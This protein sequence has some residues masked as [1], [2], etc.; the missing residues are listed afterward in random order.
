MTLSVS[1]KIRQI[2][3]A[4]LDAV[5]AELARRKLSYFVRE[6]W[7][8]LEPSTDLVWGL[9]ID[10]ICDH[11]EAVYN[12]RI[13]NLLINIPPG[14]MKSLL[15]SVF[16]Q[17]WIWL[18]NPAWQALYGSYDMGLSTRDTLRFRDLVT[19]DW[20][21]ETFRPRWRPKADQNTK[22]WFANTAGGYH[23][24]V[25][26]SGKGLGFR[27]DA[28]VFDDPLNVKRM[29]TE[30][31]LE[32]A[33]FWWD[34]RMSTR[35][36]NPRTFR[37][38]GVM[39]RLH[40]GDPSGH[41]LEVNDQRKR[42]YVH[43]RLP[44]EFDP[45]DRCETSIGFSDW[46]TEPGELLFPEL[47]GP[48]EIAEAKVNLQHHFAGQHNQR[49]VPLSGGIIQFAWIKFWY[50]RRMAPTPVRVV[51][52]DG[53]VVTCE[54]V[55]LPKSFDWKATSSDL[56]FKDKAT[57]SLVA[58]QVWGGVKGDYYLLHQ[59]LD[60]MSFV[61]TLSNYRSLAGRYPEC[62]AHLVE[63][64]ANGPALMNVLRNEISGMIAI[65]PKDYGGSKESRCEAAAPLFEAGNVYIPHP[66]EVEWSDKYRQEICTFPRSRHSDQVDSTTQLLNW[67]RRRTAARRKL[68]CLAK[69]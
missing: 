32:T 52:E 63:D 69:L 66:S 4:A 30:E 62:N 6:G 37:S 1:N 55:R 26:V 13:Y 67:A 7:H 22:T 64:K 47:Y 29:P 24:A 10:A 56:A 43:L 36:N 39:Q 18:D 14:H 33:I 65:N 25:S 53:E 38:V 8:V 9:H 27:G 3:V 31:E 23:M 49:P 41:I 15:V 5:H 40:E 17:A 42:P 20:Y 28:R 61:A 68:A 11:L 21:R 35:S 48:D 50:R 2:P 59:I 34:K 12:G 45:D 44:T 16:W 54:Q 19:S 60:H 51:L 58:M 57:N 46:R